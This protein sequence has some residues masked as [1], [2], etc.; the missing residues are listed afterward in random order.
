ML[1]FGLPPTNTAEFK[2]GNSC[3]RI[4]LLLQTSSSEVPGSS[5][6]TVVFEIQAA[7]KILSF[8]HLFDIKSTF[9]V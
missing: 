9:I 2:Y 8:I 5:S 6:S 1:G 4:A 7:K 3:G